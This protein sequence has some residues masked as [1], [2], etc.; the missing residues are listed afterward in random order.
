MYGF[1]RARLVKSAIALLVLGA[2]LFNPLHAETVLKIATLAP[3]STS[4]MKIMR[5]GADEIEQQTQGRVKIKFYPGGVMGN[6]KVVLRKMR[7][8]QLHGGALMSGSLAGVYPDAQLYSLPFLFKNLEEINYV[9][10]HMDAVIRDGLEQNG[11]VSLGM[12]NGGFAYIASTDPASSLQDIRQQKVWLPQGDKVGAIMFKA[13]DISPVPLP[14]SDVYTALQTGLLNT[15]VSNPSSVIAFQWHT[16]VQYLTDAPIVFLVG[17]LVVDKKIFDKLSVDDRQIVRKVMGEKS[18]KLDSLSQRDN[19][20]ALQVLRDNGIKFLTSTAEE[21]ASWSTIAASTWN[22]LQENGA[23]TSGNF[24]LL[25]KH[26]DAYRNDKVA[27][28]DK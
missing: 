26:L 27:L 11:L 9:R 8:G 23:Y 28:H 22:E 18:V 15:V 19:E 3:D 12:I 20:A 1:F 21:K 16:K 13:A 24:A 7:I 17:I 5:E 14:I 2:M 6:D 25:R 4:W 10:K